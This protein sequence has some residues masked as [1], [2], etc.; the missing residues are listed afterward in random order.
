M[1][2]TIIYHINCP[3]QPDG[4]AP[5]F[6][7]DGHIVGDMICPACGDGIMICIEIEGDED[8]E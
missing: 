1:I 2:N 4:E 5:V 7:G 3:K 8:N 6:T